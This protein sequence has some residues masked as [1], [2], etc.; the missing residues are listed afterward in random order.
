MKKKVLSALLVAAMTA[1]LFAGCGGKDEDKPST[2]ATPDASQG[3]ENPTTEENIDYGEGTITLWV[4]EAAVDFTKEQ[5]DAFLKENAPGYKAT[6][7]AVG[8]ADAAGN[9]ITDVEGGADIFSFAQDQL[10]RL[11]AA[12]AVQPIIE[13]YASWI[14]EN[15]DEGSVAA[16]KSGDMSYAFPLTSDNGYFLFYDKSV[17]TK[18]DSLEDILADCEKA[19][20]NFYM[21]INAGWY[22]PSFFFGTGCKGEYETDVDGNFTSCTMDFAS[23]KGLVAMKE[24]IATAEAK[25]FQNGSNSDEATN[26]AAIVTGTWNADSIKK[27][28]GDNY[29]CAKMPSFEGSDGQTYQMSGFK[30]YKMLGIKPQT[31]EG[32]L[33]LCYKLAQYLTD[34]ERQVAR[35]EKVGWGPSNLEAQGNDAVQA[36]VALTA[37]RDQFEFS[38]PQGQYPNDY[39]TLVTSFSDTIISGDI[40]SKTSDDDLMKKLQEFQDTCMGYAK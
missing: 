26:Y 18:P 10:A 25:A 3:A 11:V 2:P 5:V 4:A 7:E 22:M 14:A 16:V 8:E 19:G 20:K 27:E 34:A 31:E 12:G 38:I 6:V 21:E 24:L 15:N 37:L 36:D 32:K 40:S 35:Y 30:G 1:T 29:A 39:W 17:V 23:D 9:M 13:P 33:A 28:F